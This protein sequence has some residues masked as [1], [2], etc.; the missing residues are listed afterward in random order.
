MNGKTSSPH[1]H[2]VSG[3]IPVKENDGPHFHWSLRF[4]KWKLIKGS[5]GWNSQGWSGPNGSNITDCTDRILSVTSLLY[6]LEN[7]ESERNDVSTQHPA[8]L[9]QLLDILLPYEDRAL[10]VPDP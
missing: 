10:K 9:Q 6:D 7:D 5:P 4:G 8:I 2:L 3:M 1:D